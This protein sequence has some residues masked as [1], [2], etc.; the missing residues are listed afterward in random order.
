MI[1]QQLAPVPQIGPA[2]EQTLSN[3][4]QY[5]PTLLSAL[6]ILLVGLVVGRILGA[7]VRR[8]VRRLSID[9][10][11]KG[12]AMEDAGGDDAVAH[13]L[14]KIA[15][16]YVYFIAILA[17]VD[18]L[19]IPRLTDILS[20]VASF[21]P[22]V[23]GALVVLVVGFVVARIIGDIVATIVGDFGVG[24]YLRETPFENLG[25][26]DGEFG[27][28]VGKLVTYYVYLLTLIAV[29]DILEITALSTLLDT[30]ASYLPALVAGLLVL[31]V[32]VWVAE[33][34]ADLVASTDD[35][36]LIYGVSLG[37][38]L[39]IYYLTIT[40]ALATVGIDVT[41][42]TTLFTAFVAAFF[43][44]LALALAIG[45][46]IAVGFGGQDYVAENID[47]WVDTAVGAA[48]EEDTP[49]FD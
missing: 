23:L 41:A 38:K 24:Q 47:D 2:I 49:E 19:G 12:T 17:A 29:A 37:V 10:Y 28:L 34:V 31:L 15:A 40:V 26:R 45:I 25:D 21:L 36:R 8:I 48:T 16:Y 39:L 9:R 30:F 14:G 13:A 5:L 32:G 22:V 35:T 33:R 11:T 7:I 42:I 43:G 27:R 18:V 3:V 46:G 4:I 6:L 1:T 20:E 44:A